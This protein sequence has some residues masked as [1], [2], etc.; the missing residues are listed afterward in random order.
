[1]KTAVAV[2]LC[3]LYYW[4]RGYRGQEMPTEA[5]ITAIICM[6][7]YVR[8]S[9][10][11]AFSRLAGTLIGAVWGFAFTGETRTVDMHVKTLR[12]KLGEGGA[13]IFTVRNVGY[14]LG[15]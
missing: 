14:Q 12:K 10:G 6:Q 4:L 11:Y 15:R 3:L 8:D 9:R 5:A 13:L 1:M 2:F 7:P